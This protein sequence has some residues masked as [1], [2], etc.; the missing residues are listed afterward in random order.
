[1]ESLLISAVG[2]AMTLCGI[3]IHIKHKQKKEEE[4][5]RL[6]EKHQREKF[7]RDIEKSWDVLPM[8]KIISSKE[9]AVWSPE[10]LKA[11]KIKS[12]PINRN[13]WTKKDKELFAN[14]LKKLN[15]SIPL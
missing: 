13:S 9:E 3:T 2:L 12:L 8:N 14:T 1:M 10:D 6:M 11:T 4:I 5:I 15:K 7:I